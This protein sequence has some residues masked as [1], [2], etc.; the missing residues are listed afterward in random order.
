MCSQ[1][2]NL[3]TKTKIEMDQSLPYRMPK[4]I[5]ISAKLNDPKYGKM[6][7]HTNAERHRQNVQ[8]ANKE[9]CISLHVKCPSQRSTSPSHSEAALYLLF[10]DRG[11]TWTSYYGT[12]LCVCGYSTVCWSFRWN[13]WYKNTTVQT[14]LDSILEGQFPC[15]P[16]FFPCENIPYSKDS[17]IFWQYHSIPVQADDSSHLLQ[18]PPLR[19][20]GKR[21]AG[22]RMIITRIPKG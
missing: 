22:F 2:R 20:R 3:I 11:L 21:L 9:L 6:H 1:T 17:P 15:F 18:M 12:Y 8:I 7:I 16:S 5:S 14:V 13:P 4:D 10:M 19:M